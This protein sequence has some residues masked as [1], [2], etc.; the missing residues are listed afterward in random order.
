MNDKGETVVM[1]LQEIKE[2]FP[3]AYN[4]IISNEVKL[5]QRKEYVTD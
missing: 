5:K 3:L 1:E 4:H 2:N